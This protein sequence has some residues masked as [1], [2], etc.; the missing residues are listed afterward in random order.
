MQCA[1]MYRQANTTDF[2]QDGSHKEQVS[3][4]GEP[5]ERTKDL[6]TVQVTQHADVRW[7]EQAAAE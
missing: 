2:C 4:A 6:C 3:F 1:P 5:Q 7:Y